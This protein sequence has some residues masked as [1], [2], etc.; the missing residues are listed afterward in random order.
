M[1]HL[2]NRLRSY[3]EIRKKYSDTAEVSTKQSNFAMNVKIALDNLRDHPLKIYD[4]ESFMKVKGVGP[5]M[6]EVVNASLF[7]LYPPEKPS[8]FEMSMMEAVMQH[9]S[10]KRKKAR[11]T[12]KGTEPVH[13]APVDIVKDPPKKA[14]YVPKMG[15]ANYAFLIVLYVEQHGSNQRE[16]L[17]K[18]QLMNLAEGSCLSDTPIHSEGRATTNRTFYNGW[19]SFKSLVNHNLAYTWGNPKKISLT[20]NGTALAEKLYHDAV[21]RGKLKPDDAIPVSN[22]GPSIDRS[23]VG[24]RPKMTGAA[25]KPSAV[26]F[27]ESDFVRNKNRQQVLPASTIDPAIDGFQNMSGM[28]RKSMAV[29]FVESDNITSKNWHQAHAQRMPPLT[30]G[31][32]FS[33]EYD[34][35]LLIDGRE[36]YF[37]MAGSAGRGESLETHVERIRNNNCDAEIRTLPIGDVLWVARRK[38]NPREEYV[39]DYIIE[40]KSLQDLIQSVKGS[41][42]YYSQKYRLQHCGL[43]NVYYLVEGDIEGLGSSTDYK[44][45]CTSCAK[46]STIDGF[47]VLRTRSVAETLALY[48]RMTCSIVL[49]YDSR[50]LDQ[51]SA[52]QSR[53]PRYSEFDEH[54]RRFEKDTLKLQDIWALMLNEVPGLGPEVCASIVQEYPTPRHL[55]RALKRKESVSDGECILAQVPMR[56]SSSRGSKVGIS[57]SKNVLSHLFF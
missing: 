18:E 11:R 15:S 21:A 55:W 13:E 40:R 32:S 57:K 35:V 25:K 14:P 19:S 29:S 53:S 44:L 20:N 8:H 45:V 48:R 52:R 7:A 33:Q 17:T 34:V 4:A 38:D 9:E 50:S 31:Q 22:I 37:R 43:N 2:D 24:D 26:S 12:Q 28:T 47:H 41:G 49:L 5:K 39:L 1:C 10:S 54:C 6:A 3:R 27:I 23:A 30:D 46:T 16:F 56:R 42:R 51:M 36:Q